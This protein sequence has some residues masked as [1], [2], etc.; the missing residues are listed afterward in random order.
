M[1][2]CRGEKH[3]KRGVFIIS[4]GEFASLSK[5]FYL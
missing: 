1:L 5:I 3:L 4:T 2:V